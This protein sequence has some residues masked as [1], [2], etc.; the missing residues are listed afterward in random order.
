MGICSHRHLKHPPYKLGYQPYKVNQYSQYV[1]NSSVLHILIQ[2][3]QMW[4]S[5][6]EKGLSTATGDIKVQPRIA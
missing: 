5:K 1:D 2:K 4:P 3:H 6:A